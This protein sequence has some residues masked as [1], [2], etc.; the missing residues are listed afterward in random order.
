MPCSTCNK[1]SVLMM[2]GLCIPCWREKEDKMLA[3]QADI[4]NT[5]RDTMGAMASGELTTARRLL[6]KA[7]A[8]SEERKKLRDL[9]G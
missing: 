9:L 7:K 3:A 6:E 5:Y 1:P 8:K 2:G 4:T